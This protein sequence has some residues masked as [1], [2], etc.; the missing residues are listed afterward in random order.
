MS[1]AFDRKTSFSIQGSRWRRLNPDGSYPA[2]DRQIGFLGTIDVSG[3][4]ALG[5]MVYRLGGSGSWTL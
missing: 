1:F 4:T 5:N 3:L 2:V